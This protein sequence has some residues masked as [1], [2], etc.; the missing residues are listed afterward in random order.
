MNHNIDSVIDR[1]VEAVARLQSALFARSQ[2][3]I[4]RYSKGYH[5]DFDQLRQSVQGAALDE[6]QQER[7]R[8]L[9]LQHRRMMRICQQS[10]MLT[11]EDLALIGQG[12]TKLKQAAK[13]ADGL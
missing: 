13:V 6:Q 9:E 3:N 4:K 5:Y 8:K 10:M 11:S 12:V 1:C 2:D 7:L